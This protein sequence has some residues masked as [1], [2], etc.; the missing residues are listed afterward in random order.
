MHLQLLS[1]K[2]VLVTALM[3]GAGASQTQAQ[4]GNVYGA[5]EYERDYYDQAYYEQAYAVDGYRHSSAEPVRSYVSYENQV[6]YDSASAGYSRRTV[7]Y[8]GRPLV[9][10]T[11]RSRPRPVLV[12]RPIQQTVYVESPRYVSRST[13]YTS[14]YP[15]YY[16]GQVYYDRAVYKSC[17]PK[18]THGIHFGIYIGSSDDRCHSRKAC[19]STSKS[20]HTHHGYY[21]KKSGFSKKD[22]HSHKSHVKQYR[23]FSGKH[24]RASGAGLLN[25]HNQ[26]SRRGHRHH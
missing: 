20:R 4:Y 8:G 15:A 13:C 19:Y 16:G 10:E 14:G 25:N 23:K 22:N 6:Y 12:E 18:R 7:S 24:R 3:L 11:P 9:M 1:T 2:T 26:S 5:Y 17:K 21:G